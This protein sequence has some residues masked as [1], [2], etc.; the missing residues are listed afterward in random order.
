MRRLRE[1]FE[2]WGK[3]YHQ[4]PLSARL[5]ARLTD[6]QELHIALME[7]ND[8]AIVDTF[9]K[10]NADIAASLDRAKQIIRPAFAPPG[11]VHISQIVRC[12]KMLDEA[13]VALADLSNLMHRLEERVTARQL[14]AANTDDAR[15][16]FTPV[17]QDAAMQLLLLSGQQVPSALPV[18]EQARIVKEARLRWVLTLE[19]TGRTAQDLVK[20]LFDA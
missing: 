11:V 6:R 8:S 12:L 14:L 5:D 18:G 2:G 13:E 3:V 7:A 9:R 1:K 20:E 4:L 17:E 19:L 10:E 15:A 16:G